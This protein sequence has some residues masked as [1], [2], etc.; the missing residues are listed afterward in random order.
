[1]TTRGTADPGLGFDE[2]GGGPMMAVH[3]LMTPNP[4]TVVLELLEES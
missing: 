3:D 1:V 4:V 2:V